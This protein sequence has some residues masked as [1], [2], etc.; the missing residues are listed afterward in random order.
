MK[1]IKVL[2]VLGSTNMG[3]AQMF[4]LNLLRNMDL[5]HYQVDFVVNFDERD[6]GIG[7][8]VVELGCNIYKLPYFKVYNYISFV[9][10]WEKFLQE[11]HYD[12]IHG[13]S[14]NSAPI[15]L[16]TAKNFGIITVAHCHSA[17]FRGN[18]IQRI[19]KKYLT[20]Q[21]KSVADYWFAC[22]AIAA[23]HLY[24]KGYRNYQRYYDIPNA[25][26]VEKYRYDE[27]IAKNIRFHLNI[28]DDILLYGH[29][30]SFTTPKNHQYLLEIF[31]E[32]LNTNPNARLL[33]CGDGPLRENVIEKAKSLSIL[34]KIIFTGNVKNIHEYLMAMDALIFPSLFEGFPIS[35]IEAEATGLPIV[36]S[37]VITTE[38]D[39][40]NLIHR[41]PLNHSPAKWAKE[42][43]KLVS[44]N[45]T[46][47]NRIIAESKYNMQTCAKMIEALYVE[48]LEQK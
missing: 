38:V 18:L 30:G 2:M 28:S 39:L 27:N 21:I 22:S 10:A 7:K 43:S 5:T 23:Q 47:Y 24:G 17:G 41:L 48:M 11:H 25:I 42:L 33:C 15:Y 36:M 35:I 46:S 12:I 20:K 37:D 3:G 32:I 9:K 4:I 1:K 40:T 26:N 45:R 19:L 13:H 34:D 8:E 14:T 44:L 16:S 6:G 31:K 29:V